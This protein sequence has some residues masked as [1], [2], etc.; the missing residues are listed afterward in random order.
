MNETLNI[1]KGIFP[2]SQDRRIERHTN[3]YDIQ[4]YCPEKGGLDKL[5]LPIQTTPTFDLNQMR[6]CI[7]LA[8][9]NESI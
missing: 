1:H 7:F 9:P 2:F 6:R 5:L 4:S 3:Q 8:Y